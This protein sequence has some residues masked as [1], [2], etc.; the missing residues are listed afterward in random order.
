[1]TLMEKMQETYED[2]REEGHILAKLEDI[3]NMHQCDIYADVVSK[4]T[5]YDE[6]LIE[7]TFELIDEEKI[8]NAEDLFEQLKKYNLM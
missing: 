4:V 3:I 8:N 6:T 2:G 1:M 7:K 5:G